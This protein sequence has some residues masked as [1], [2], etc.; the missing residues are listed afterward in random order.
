MTVPAHPLFIRIFAVMLAAVAVVQLSTFALIILTGPPT[1][2]FRTAPQVASSLRNGPGTSNDFAVAWRTGTPN[3]QPA[4]MFAQLVAADLGIEPG[5]VQAVRHLPPQGAPP[6]GLA[7]AAGYDSRAGPLFGDFEVAVRASDGRW[8][9]ARPILHDF[10]HWRRNALLWLVAATFITAPFAWWLARWTALPVRRFAI[11]AERVGRNARAPSLD[12]SG[13]RE[14][15]EAAQAFNEMQQRIHNQLRERTVIVGAIA[16]DLRTPMT[17]LVLRLRDAS[18]ALRESVD[19]DLADMDAMIVAIA[20]FVEAETLQ[21]EPRT[22]DFGS[23]VHSLVDNYADA[24]K[25]V[26]M[27]SEEEDDYRVSGKAT[28]LKAMVSNLIENALKYAGS[29]DVELLRD[30]QNVT[31]EVRDSGAGVPEAELDHIFEPF[32]RGEK[33]RS[34]ETGGLG[35]GL[36]AVRAVARAHGGDSTIANRPQGGAI[37]RVTLPAYDRGSMKF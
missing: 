20:R 9:T 32:Y 28:A 5:R 19:A 8:L 13:P 22:I 10:A 6:F 36:A 18:P 29:A 11:A 1:D 31:L 4:P 27:A 26:T 33:S 17:R 7:K 15:V 21:I 23:M 16:H 35:L 25:P 34:R 37:A 12:L 30:F 14:I 24:G 2:A 3:G